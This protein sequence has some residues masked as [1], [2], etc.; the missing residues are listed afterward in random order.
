MIILKGIGTQGFAKGKAFKVERQSA[1]E[2]VSQGKGVSVDFASLSGQERISAIEAEKQHFLQSLSIV[3]EDLRQLASS[4]SSEMSDIFAAHL[5]MADDPL[6]EEETIGFI[7][8]GN[9]AVDALACEE[10][11]ICAMFADIDD[12][13]LKARTED[14]RDVCGR[15]ARKL[16]MSEQNAFE[17]IPDGSIIVA[18]SLSPSDTALMDFS[19]IRG[20]VTEKGSA[21]SHV[22][23]IAHT[24][25]IPAIV[26]VKGCLDAV[27]DGDEILVNGLTDTVIVNPSDQ[28]IE[29]Y[30]SNASAYLQR[31]TNAVSAASERVVTGGGKS[32]F[33]YG[34]A[35][36]VQ[37]VRLAIEAGADGIGLF[38]SEFLY[39]DSQDFPSEETQFEAYRA[40][41][42]IAGQR[43]L[44]IR[45]LD[46]GGDKD[47]SYMQLP[48]EENPFLGVRA[49]RL[50]LERQDMFKT[51]IRAILRSATFGNVRMLIPML[52]CVD[53]LKK[54]R[55]L[56]GIC[57]RELRNEGVDCNPD[58]PVGVMI[59]TPAAAIAS[60]I[61]AKEA[62]FFS[63]GT[64]DLVQY[65]MAADRGNSY[66]SQLYDMRNVSVQRL[67]KLIADNAAS[68]GIEV[69]ICGEAASD[70]SLSET[71]IQMGYSSFSVSA[72][73]VA[74][75]KDNLR[76]VD[77]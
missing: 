38:R 56:V 35:G 53:E 57:A 61:I 6:L 31:M 20:F 9:C 49:V 36:N 51:Q 21:T 13:Y 72:P 11:K 69:E 8:E 52:T 48:R 23:I 74:L 47:L 63:V 43:P 22:C 41:A 7:E 37:D 67:M 46:I 25:G 42:E 73:S 2:S 16:S 65:V 34:N 62:D 50:C 75:L 3:K 5:E 17:C 39:M 32:C 33:V 4:S 1:P 60:D 55:E 10:Q 45:T 77:F 14:I 26:G 27:S 28:A 29:E 40:A 44:V 19:K 12:E 54:V 68:A 30:E 59:E 64:N 66:V 71:F 58:I 24:K 76:Q 18:E 70:L 15:L